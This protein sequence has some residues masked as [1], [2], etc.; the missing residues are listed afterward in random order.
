[1]RECAG[2]LKGARI[3]FSGKWVFCAV[4]LLSYLAKEKREDPSQ[5]RVR[6]APLQKSTPYWQDKY[7]PV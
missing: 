7:L 5:L 1:M 6:N 2:N 3:K 4:L